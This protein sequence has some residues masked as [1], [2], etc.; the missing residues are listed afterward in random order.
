MA[1]TKRDG[2][3]I[4]METLQVFQNHWN[5]GNRWMVHLLTKSHMILK[6]LDILMEMSDQVQVELTITTLDE[7]RKKL[8]EGYAPTVKKRLDVIE[9][10][11]NS[12]IFVRVMCMP[13]IETFEE[14]AEVRNV[15]IDRG[16]SGF[17]HKKLNYFDEQALLA[18]DLI[19]VKGRN[20]TMFEDLLLFLQHLQ[21]LHYY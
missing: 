5:Q 9:R 6:H 20:D 19:R 17:K 12:G 8:L 7:E 2:R 18:G 3:D 4:L 10:L 16:A 15:V 21:Y 1:K 13:F 14:A 11:A